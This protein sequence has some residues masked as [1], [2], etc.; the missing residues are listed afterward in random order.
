M[1]QRAQRV[2]DDQRDLDLVVER[3]RVPVDH[4]D[5]GLQELAVAPLLR[6]LAPPRLLDLVAPE[7]E[8]Q[9]AR[10]LQDIPGERHGQVEVQPERVVGGIVRVGLQAAQHVHLLGGLA[11]AQQLVERLDGAGLQRREAVQLERRAQVVEHVLLDHALRRQP[12]GEPAQ[13]G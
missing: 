7:R 13:R 6:A 1:R 2:A 12:L 9:L 11:L 3:Q 10:V 8:L 4:V 5:V